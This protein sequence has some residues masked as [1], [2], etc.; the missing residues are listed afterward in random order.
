MTPVTA[1][2]IQI[3][4]LA[5]SAARWRI[6]T[7]GCRQKD[8]EY[9]DGWVDEFIALAATS[10]WEKTNPSSAIRSLLQLGHEDSKPPRR[11]DAGSNG[12]RRLDLNQL[13]VG[14]AALNYLCRNVR[15]LGA[16]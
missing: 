8:V 12:Q 10:R 11:G 3:S 6:R 16:T 14:K 9:H 4:G 2:Q 5:A 1:E 13:D 15:E 7:L